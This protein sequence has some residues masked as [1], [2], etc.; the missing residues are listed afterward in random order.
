MHRLWKTFRRV[1][2]NTLKMLGCCNPTLGQTWASPTVGIKKR[3]L[4]LIEKMNTMLSL[5]IFDQ[6]LGYYNPAFF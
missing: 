1:D 4:N 3:H 2:N 6:T 5:S